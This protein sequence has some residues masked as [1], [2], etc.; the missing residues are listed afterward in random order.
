MAFVPP[1]ERKFKTIPYA[2]DKRYM[3]YKAIARIKKA[4]STDPEKIVDAFADLTIS[5]RGR[6]YN[7]VRARDPT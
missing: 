1:N 4:G 2:R 3:T 5:D 7:H 6:F